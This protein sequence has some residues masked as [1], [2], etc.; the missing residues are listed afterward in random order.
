MTVVE[1][2]AQNL[3]VAFGGSNHGARFDRIERHRLLA[4]HVQSSLQCCDRCWRVELVR[5]TDDDRIKFF[6]L[7]HVAVVGIHRGNFILLCR[8]FCQIDDDIGD[9]GESNVGMLLEAGEMTPARNC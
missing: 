9:G 2:D 6:T 3:A 7:E 5:R 8:R 4:E 1:C